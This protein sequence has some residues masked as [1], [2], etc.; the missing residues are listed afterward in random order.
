MSGSCGTE[1]SAVSGALDE[2]TG[3]FDGPDDTV[4]GFGLDV[5]AE[6]EEAADAFAFELLTD[7]TVLLF[8]AVCTG[9]DR[10]ALFVSEWIY[11]DDVSAAAVPLVISL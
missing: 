7:E 6:V 11:S 3:G 9:S 4:G 8:S 2:D 10:K 1:D 5:D